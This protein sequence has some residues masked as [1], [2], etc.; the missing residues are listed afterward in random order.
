MADHV[1]D[2]HIWVPGAETA[3]LIFLCDHAAHAVPGDLGDLGLPAEQF[4]RHI[5]Y[6]IGAADVTRALASVFDAPAILG[7]W[8]RLVIDLNRGSDDPTIVMK[9]SDGAIIPGNAHAAETEIARRIGRWHA[10]YHAA[11][12]A[13]IDTCLAA[14]IT[15]VLVSVHSFT[16]VW[17]GA[18]RPWDV[19]ILWDRDPRLAQPLLDTLRAEPGLTIG[20]NEPYHGA[21]LGDTLWQ[22]GTSRGL[23]H[24]L[25]EIRQ[26]LIADPAGITAMAAMLTRVLTKAL[27]RMDE[28]V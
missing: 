13:H 17:K 25:I 16:P 1:F 4:T 12:G 14:R 19:S 27:A 20:D 21:L 3:R 24:A 2:S 15:P 11:I 5:A 7:R 18:A 26:D 8:S 10:P 22:H 28:S 6:D 9:L 23:A